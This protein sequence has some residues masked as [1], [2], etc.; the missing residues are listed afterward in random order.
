ML[1]VR[2]P[3]GLAPD[4]RDV[5]A[6][7]RLG[8]GETYDLRLPGRQGGTTRAFELLAAE[9]HHGRQADAE[10]TE[11][12]PHEAAAAAARQLVGGDQLAEHVKLLGTEA[13]RGRSVDV[14]GRPRAAHAAAQDADLGHAVEE[15][16]RQLLG[17]VPGVDMG[18]I[19]ASTNW[20]TAA[21]SW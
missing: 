17:L 2:A 12:A 21:R 11:H 9:L 20:R 15:L 13:S 8:D 3:F 5:A 16:A 6:R 7:V 4:V 10:A 1:A 18:V 19:S 14:L